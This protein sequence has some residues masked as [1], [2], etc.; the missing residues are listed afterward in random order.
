MR[1]ETEGGI[2]VGEGRALAGVRITASVSPHHRHRHA[3]HQVNVIEMS[4]PDPFASSS[5]TVHAIR[6]VKQGTEKRVAGGYPVDIRARGIASCGQPSPSI[7]TPPA[8]SVLGG[9]PCVV[10]PHAA[11][12]LRKDVASLFYSRA[13]EKRFRQEAAVDDEWCESLEDD[14]LTSLS[15]DELEDPATDQQRG[16]WSPTRERKDYAIS[17]AVVVFGEATMTYD[18][19][20]AGGCAVEAALEAERASSFSFDDAAF[21]NGQLTWS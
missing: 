21:W 9:R 3:E 5:I 11:S 16:L 10:H 14:S 8:E 18:G 20:H 17:K 15:N 2:I 4:V 7:T 12:T 6:R 13:D 1:T 19:S